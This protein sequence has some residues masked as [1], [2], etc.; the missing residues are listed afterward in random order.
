M[1]T[2]DTITRRHPDDVRDAVN[3][4]AISKSDLATR[5]QVHVNTLA[6]LDSPK[7]NPKW[8]TLDALCRAAEEIKAERS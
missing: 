5:A 4:S 1:D 6:E 2:Q 3:R 7:W 8:R